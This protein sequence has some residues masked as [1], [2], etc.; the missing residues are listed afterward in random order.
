MDETQPDLGKT[1]AQ[2]ALEPKRAK[3][4]QGEVEQHSL[5]DQIEA[6]RYLRNRKAGKR[7]LRAVG[8]SRVTPPG[9]V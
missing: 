9:S 3:G 2:S 7:G 8:L 5:K 6:D 4:D 1:I